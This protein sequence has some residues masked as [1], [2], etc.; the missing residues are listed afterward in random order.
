MLAWRSRARWRRPAVRGAALGGLRGLPLPALS[1]EG[2]IG[3]EWPSGACTGSWH[4]L[5][6]DLFVSGT[7][8]PTPW[9]AFV[10]LGMC[11][12]R[13]RMRERR[14]AAW[15]VAGGLAALSGGYVLAALIEPL[16][17]DEWAWIA[18]TDPLDRMAAS[19]I[20]DGRRLGRG[21]GRAAAAG[22]LRV[23]DVGA[24]RALAGLGQLTFTLYLAHG[25]LAAAVLRWVWDDPGV[26]LVGALALAAGF[27]ACALPFSLAY[28]RHHA[29][30]RRR[31]CLRRFGG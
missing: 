12:G 8:P 14:M 25:L 23:P 7:H 2:G 9:L 5:T 26:G 27:W 21:R 30:G 31:W 22:G 3:L 10:F 1:V 15:L 18:S 16:A 28:R 11:L 29:R 17:A 6:A 20:V 19:T 4:E 24:I 13:L